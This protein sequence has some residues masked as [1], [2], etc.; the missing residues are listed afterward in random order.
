V[1]DRDRGQSEALG[2]LLIFGVVVLTIALV[3]TAGFAGLDDVQDFQRTSNAEQA[4]RV[5]ADNVDDVVGDGAPGRSTEVRLSG[6][7]L[8]LATTETTV[9]VT[10]DDG[11]ANTTT[12][13]PHRVVYGSGTGT[14]ITYRSG[15]V[16]RAD[17][18]SPVLLRD[19]G[20]VVTDE[21]VILPLVDASPAGANR[22]GG[23][24]A[25]TVRTRD[26]GAEV[27]AAD[28]SVDSVTLNVSSPHAEAWERYFERYADGG[29]VTG[30]ARNGDSVEVTIDTERAYVTV[31]RIDVRFQ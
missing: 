6:A 7:S 4:F 20:F 19:P 15:A 3:G 24:T 26:A 5:L 25:V 16:V 2:F 14:T 9:T 31:H 12:V 17:D 11:S 13:E 1:R 10:D 28:D 22:V 29:P 18:G 8:S 23:T 21:V 30:V 27:L